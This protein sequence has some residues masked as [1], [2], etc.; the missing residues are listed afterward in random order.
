[1]FDS[2]ELKRKA[3]LTTV[4]TSPQGVEGWDQNVTRPRA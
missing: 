2:E 4:W 1:M 3:P